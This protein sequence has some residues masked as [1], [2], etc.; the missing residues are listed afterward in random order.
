MPWKRRSIG[1]GGPPASAEPAKPLAANSN[2]QTGA[3]ASRPPTGSKVI[4]P[5]TAIR[6]PRPN[7]PATASAA[8]AAKQVA[9]VKLPTGGAE[10]APLSS[11][12]VGVD[13][14]FDDTLTASK[15]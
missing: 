6:R 15:G 10:Q 5:A 12:E 14:D 4:V 3:H 1:K 7:E 8:P 13:L 11:D 9:G 2:D